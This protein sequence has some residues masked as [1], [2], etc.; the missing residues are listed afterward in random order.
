MGTILLGLYEVLHV[1]RGGGMGLVYRVRH[2]QW[3][4]D[5]ALKQPRREYFHTSAQVE[6]FRQECDTWIR[7]GLHPQI[8]S[9][10]YVR[11]HEGIPLVFAEYLAGGSLEEWIDD[12]SLYAGGP[13]RSLARILDIAIQAAWGLA[14]AHA[15]KLVHRDVKPANVVL[16][17]DGAAKL[18][19]FGLAAA[20]EGSASTPGYRSP[21]QARRLP[22]TDRSDVWSWAVSVLEMF[23]GGLAWPDG[24]DADNAIHRWRH[25]TVPQG[26]PPLPDAVSQILL[27]CLGRNPARRPS[28]VAVTRELLNVYKVLVQS[29]YPRTDIRR[30]VETGETGLSPLIAS[31][32]ESNRALSLLDLA[33]E[34]HPD[35]W[36]EAESKLRHWL[37]IHPRDPVPWC[38]WQLLKLSRGRTSAIMLAKDYFD[39]IVPQRP[40]WH[41]L[42]VDAD[43]FLKFTG[44]YFLRH[45]RSPVL[46]VLWRVVDGALITASTDGSI[47]VWAAGAFGWEL[48][49]TVRNPGVAVSDLSI[50]P[51]GSTLIVGLADGTVEA[52]DIWDGALLSLT[53]PTVEEP[54][55]RSA[56]VGLS[57]VRVIRYFGNT[58]VLIGLS[59]DEWVL[60]SLPSLQ[61]LEIGRGRSDGVVGSAAPNNPGYWVAAFEDGVIRT[62][63]G[64]DDGKALAHVLRPLKTIRLLEPE[65]A[66][67]LGTHPRVAFGPIGMSPDG[68]WAVCGTRNGSLFVW[69]VADMFSSSFSPS[70]WVYAGSI[71]AVVFS[72]DSSRLFFADADGWVRMIALE[73]LNPIDIVQ[74]RDPVCC[75]EV[76]PEDNQLAIGCSTGSVLLHRLDSKPAVI[77]F[78][79]AR[80]RSSEEHL[81]VNARKD[82]LAKGATEALASERYGEA[83]ELATT[84]LALCSGDATD[85][86]FLDLILSLPVHRY[87][88]R[89]VKLRWSLSNVYGST[90]ATR[91]GPTITGL[92][93]GSR[94]SNNLVVGSDE[95]L[96]RLRTTDGADLERLEI[97]RIRAV[98][99]DEM[100]NSCVAALDG[101]G[102]RTDVLRQP[103]PNRAIA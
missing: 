34:C 66:T 15:R 10:Y 95:A 53:A 65:S 51:N 26:V 62:F 27:K 61:I 43:R 23:A 99:Y 44:S 1:H 58:R 24:S 52:R 3:D 71:S 63:V 21:E 47:L 48:I 13:E 45:G 86:G 50:T 54:R 14:Y 93:V 57:S 83:Y 12:R 74:T 102:N 77:P 41:E 7:L 35:R 46:R 73:A 22:I 88:L 101:G 36:R 79:L 59:S 11:V 98:Y 82:E 92:A 4:V 96:H 87:A 64:D 81:K 29:A 78:L 70:C 60:L 75:L 32:D 16:T 2:L 69:R 56:A 25:I 76:A 17:P 19:D 80:P 55:S 31:G 18:T 6:L 67:R 5:L 100:N 91:V 84:G 30:G 68:K 97:R 33:D 20:V 40:S 89:Q 9:C 90:T 94:G 85:E 72:L 39:T 8:A 37:E 42:G 103:W 38:N 28:I 49:R